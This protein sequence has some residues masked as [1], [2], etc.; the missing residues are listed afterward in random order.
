VAVDRGGRGSAARTNG[1]R[2]GDGPVATRSTSRSRRSD[3][4][5][6]RRD[7]L[8]GRPLEPIAAAARGVI[9]SWRRRSARSREPSWRARPQA[10]YRRGVRELFVPRATITARY[11]GPSP[12]YKTPS[13][14]PGWAAPDEHDEYAVERHDGAADVRALDRARERVTYAG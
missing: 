10:R 11:A 7:P 2:R 3:A 6:A 5:G 8:G 14:R 12:D 13:T 9:G 4:P 1:F